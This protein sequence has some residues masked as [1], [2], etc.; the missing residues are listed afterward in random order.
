LALFNLAID[1]KLRGCDLIAL[2]VS[3]VAPNGYA[4]DRASVRQKKTGRPVRFELTEQ[5]RQSVDEYLRNTGR[6][7]A[8][9]L[10]PGRGGFDRSLTT[11]QYARLVARWVS[12]DTPRAIAACDEAIKAHPEEPRYLYQRGRAHSRAARLAETAKDEAAAKLS[13][14]SALH[15]LEAAMSKGYPMAFNNMANALQLGKGIA[16]DEGKAAARRASIARASNNWRRMASDP[17]RSP[18]SWEWRAAQCTGYLMKVDQ[19][20]CASHQLKDVG[21]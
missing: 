1:S 2:R 10:F 21:L 18:A 14:A 3:D 8:Q 13:D 4:L 12:I 20:K 16:K 5:T 19:L 17:G 7:P 6:E 15:D 11:R 9:F